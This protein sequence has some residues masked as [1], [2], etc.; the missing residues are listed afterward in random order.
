MLP[1]AGPH[2]KTLKSYC[3]VYILS[4]ADRYFRSVA[5]HA[6]FNPS[7]LDLNPASRRRQVAVALHEITHA[8]GF[9]SGKFTDF[10]RWVNA[11]EFE[12][13]PLADIYLEATLPG[14]KSAAFIKS[15]NVLSFVRQHFDC[16]SL[17]GVSNSEQAFLKDEF[18]IEN[19]LFIC[20]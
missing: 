3:R 19:F 13:I 8:L 5:G 9:S 1:L 4:I 17:L 20:D 2:S 18:S 16:D 6:N 7:A 14:W 12:R 15:P 10:I 11:T